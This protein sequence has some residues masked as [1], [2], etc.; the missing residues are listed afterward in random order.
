VTQPNIL[1]VMFDQ[2]SGV[3]L[4]DDRIDALHIPNLRRLIA[5]GVKF[6]NAYSSSPLCTPARGAFMTGQLPSRSGIYDNA[7]EFP[8]STPTFAH[9]LR[10]LGYQTALS[11]KMHFVG[12]DQLHGFEERLTTDIYPADFGWTPDWERPHERIDWWYHNLGSV[13]EAGIAEITNQ[14]EFDDEVAY[15]ARLKLF[16]Y[17][18]RKDPRPF[19]LTASFTHP[20]DPYVARQQ[21][22]DL[23]D[24]ERIS[25][26][27]VPAFEYE[28]QDPHSQ[29]LLEAVDFRRFE[30]NAEHVRR[31]RHA[32][33]ANISYLDDRLG[34]LLRTLEQCDFAQS[35]HI[36]LCA[37]HGDMLGERGL[38]YKMNFFEASSRVPLIM[39]APG[40]AAARRVATPVALH[41][42]LPTLIGLAGGDASEIVGEIDGGDLR[43]LAAGE[44]NA[45]R[46][47]YAEYCAEGSVSPMVM[48]RRGQYKFCFCPNDPPQLFD[49]RSDPLELRNLAA[50]PVHASVA[51]EFTAIVQGRWDIVGFTSEVKR[52]QRYRQLVNHANR[53]GRFT[54]WDFQSQFDARQRFMRNHMDLNVL[55]AEAR[56]PKL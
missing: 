6:D 20:H 31:A 10:K 32:S 7:A 40:Q 3:L 11:G 8:A 14:L 19:C 47:V 41:D 44:E 43:N 28:Q 42:L 38:W 15:Q 46:A 22:W 53:L 55:E 50:D 23:Y 49:L 39:A 21:Y 56:Y 18:R 30:L 5:R 2:M 33:F 24:H 52:S 16:Q 54:A 51:A 1:I 13:T 9:Y 45:G 36:I 48:I 29:R 17:A 25:M 37:D 12:P 4:D 27:R 34:D 26:P 35:T